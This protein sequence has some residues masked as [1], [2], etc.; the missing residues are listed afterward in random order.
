MAATAQT[1]T[2]PRENVRR[3]LRETREERAAGRYVDRADIQAHVREMLAHRA[4]PQ[5]TPDTVR[6]G[7][8]ATYVQ[9]TD[10]YACEVV[11]VSPSGRKITV[12]EMNAT[13]D[14]TWHPEVTPGGFVGH[15]HNQDGQRWKLERDPNGV[16]RVAHWRAKRRCWMVGGCKVWV[17]AAG[18]GQRFHD[19][20][21]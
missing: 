18:E 19:Y 1:W 6:V 13:L 21:F 9:W 8:A 3:L 11:A 20:N 7:Q 5:I 16:V 12:R 10:S 2:C 15:C 14:P 17:H 4:L